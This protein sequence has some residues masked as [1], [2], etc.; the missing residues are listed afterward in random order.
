MLSLFHA[1]AL[2]QKLQ[3]SVLQTFGTAALELLISLS[4]LV[5]RFRGPVSIPTNTSLNMLLLPF[6]CHCG[7]SNRSQED[8]SLV[9]VIHCI[10]LFLVPH[11]IKLMY[12]CSFK[13]KLETL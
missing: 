4:V 13:F 11:L 7:I 9:A 5:L 8:G 12:I 1:S 6:S 2:Q 3:K 10:L